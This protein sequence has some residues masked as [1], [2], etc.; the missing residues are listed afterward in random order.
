MTSKFLNRLIHV[1]LVVSIIFSCTGRG[2]AQDSM[3]E[4]FADQ[5]KRCLARGQVWEAV[6]LFDQA[7]DK[8]EKDANDELYIARLH[9]DVGECYRRLAVDAAQ[10]AKVDDPV[11]REYTPEKWLALAEKNLQYSL[12]IKERRSNDRTD[13]LY[14]ARGL[15]NLAKVYSELNRNT[16][17]EALYRKA[18]GIRES[19]EGKE[20]CSS[21]SDY[22]YLGDV[23]CDMS[24]YKDAESN[25]VIALRI[26]RRCNKPDD[27]VLGV[28]H[29]HLAVLYYKWRRLSGA[30]RHYD[31]ALRIFTR[32]LPSTKNN[33]DNLKREMTDFPIESYSQSFEEWREFVEKNTANKVTQVGLLRNLLAACRRLGRD[34]D[35]W[36]NDI[37]KQ[38][39]ALGATP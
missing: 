3:A 31:E 23:L 11:Y 24:Q 22:L 1:A 33:L 20:S 13:F 34:G 28:C 19:K 27:A 18:L 29:Q 36:A 15:E 4:A 12:T 17:A 37:S 7:I 6:R 16:E 39:H 25:Y 38:L 35:I 21:A 8:E 10:R 14:I 2:S 9:N 26:F 32:N 5:G 30:G